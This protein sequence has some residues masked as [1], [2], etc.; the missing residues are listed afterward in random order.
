MGGEENKRLLDDIERDRLLTRIDTRLEIL[1]TNH[2]EYKK[3][4]DL[5]FERYDKRI[6][7]LERVYGIGVGMVIIFQVLMQF[8]R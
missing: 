5:R 7:L 2:Q 3:E 4:V 1:I 6:T 8:L